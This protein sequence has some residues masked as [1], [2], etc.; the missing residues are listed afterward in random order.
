VGGQ[1][2]LDLPHSPRVGGE[3]FLVGTCNRVAYDWLMRWPDWPG[4]GLVLTGPAGSGKS[5]L[6]A[7]WAAPAKSAVAILID[8]IE[9]ALGSPD[10]ER[11]LFHL[12]NCAKEQGGHVLL[13]ARDAP[14]QWPVAL[15][16]LRSRLLA[17][18][19]TEIAPPDDAV[20]TG[21]LAKL[22]HDRQIAV[23][24]ELIEYLVRRIDRSFAAAQDAVARLDRAALS[25]G[26][27]VTVALA[28]AVLPEVKG[29]ALQGRLFTENREP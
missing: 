15:P 21:L 6:A 1:L 24:P 17:F 8:P 18:P 12:L 20:L 25:Q 4:S 9:S 3:D 22:F 5:H 29:D 10:Q 19:V 7:L 14:S 2:P 26:R 28:R 13:V 16:D 23:T 11:A 27:G